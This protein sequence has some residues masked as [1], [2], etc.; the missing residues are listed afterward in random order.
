MGL[1]QVVLGA[2]GWAP[3]T[4]ASPWSD[5]EHL[6]NVDLV[7][8]FYLGENVRMDRGNAMKLATVARVRNAVAGRLGGLPLFYVRGGQRDAAS[9]MKLL[10]QPDPSRTRS[11]II[12]WTVDQLM[13]YP[14]TWWIVRARDSYGWPAACELVMHGD[15]E[16][17]RD[18]NLIKVKSVPV[19]AADVIRFDAPNAGLLV[20]GERT[21]RRAVV[22]E[23]AAAKAEDNPVPS[24]EL[25]NDGD[26]LTKTE[27]ETVLG[28]WVNGRRKYGVG[29]T[30]KGIKTQAHGQAPE[31][32]LI[33]ARK[34]IDLE[35]VRHMNAQAWIADVAVDGSSLTYANLSQRNR[36]LIDTT[37][38]PYMAAI[39]D[40]L[41][42]G[43]VTPRGWEVR[44]DTDQLT[45][46]DMKT[47]FETY[48]IGLAQ[49]F[50]TQEQIAAWEGW[51]VPAGAAA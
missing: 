30:S 6:E 11:S 16:L 35:L 21:L 15:A 1:K 14:C 26:Q 43:D 31:Q 13:F 10:Q 4:L 27:I 12:T 20:D 28:N 18:G 34:R 36:D 49:K 50:I 8:L 45:R 33:D 41:S 32:L 37:L 5:T 22:V 47:R 39:A 9:P 24:F 29:Y 51:P 2:L 48:A 44:F 19:A 40:R 7:D 38:A 46:D 25:H 42:L 17:D 23:M 3:F